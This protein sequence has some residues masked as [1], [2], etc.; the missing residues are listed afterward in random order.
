MTNEGRDDKDGMDRQD[1]D[2]FWTLLGR[3][4]PPALV[5]PYFSRRVLREVALA[6]QGRAAGWWGSLRSASM[7]ASV[8]RRTALWSGVFSGA[9]ALGLLCLHSGLQTPETRSARHAHVRA[10]Q[11]APTT[12]PPA[13]QTVAAAEAREA[14]PV[15]EAEV[16]ADLDNILEREES[17]LWTEDTARF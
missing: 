11:A 12:P 1:D 6:D 7:A 13:A 9:C 10:V 15:P 2:A 4:A 8:F 5:S 16:V 14:V 17:R 3:A